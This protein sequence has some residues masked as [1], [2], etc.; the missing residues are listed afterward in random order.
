MNDRHDFEVKSPHG[1]TINFDDTIGVTTDA[2]VTRKPMMMVTLD[3]RMRGKKK[4]GRYCHESLHI[5][6]PALGEKDIIDAERFIADVLW[7]AGYRRITETK[8]GRPVQ[9][10]RSGGRGET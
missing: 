7:E 3:G 2:F 4:L 1:R 8:H 9:G 5:L 6:F 10:R